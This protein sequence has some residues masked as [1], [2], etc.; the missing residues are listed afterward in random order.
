MSSTAYEVYLV[1]VC[2]Q[3]GNETLT[4]P[5]IVVVSA[6]SDC[7]SEELGFESHQ[8]YVGCFSPDWLLPRV[9]SYG[10]SGKAVTAQPSFIHFTDA[11]LAVL[12]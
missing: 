9:G 7:W 12:R 5:R 4:G 8:S 1:D 6:N 11:S 3:Q 2:L 10:T